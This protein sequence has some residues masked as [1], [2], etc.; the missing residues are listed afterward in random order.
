MPTRRAVLAAALT[1]IAAAGCSGSSSGEKQADQNT[2]VVSTFPFGVKE[3]EQAVATPF[4]K[5]TGIKVELDTGSNA[6]R[7]SK[8]KLARGEPEADVVLISDYFAAL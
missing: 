2:I 7:L 6:D 4:T 1:L 3:V 5:K 8:R